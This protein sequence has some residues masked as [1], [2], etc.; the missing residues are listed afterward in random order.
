ML[1]FWAKHIVGR[2]PI[3]KVD[4]KKPRQQPSPLWPRGDSDIPNT[5]LSNFCSWNLSFL[6]AAK[7]IAECR[8]QLA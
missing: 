3:V 5:F 4:L 2:L 1:Q 8:W 7:W 6:I